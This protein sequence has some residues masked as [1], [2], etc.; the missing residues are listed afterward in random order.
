MGAAVVGGSDL[1]PVNSELSGAAPARFATYHQ[2]GCRAGGHVRFSAPKVP[3]RQQYDT[4]GWDF[5]EGAYYRASDRE[6]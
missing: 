5:Q 3:P 1:G 6:Q 2:I 4:M